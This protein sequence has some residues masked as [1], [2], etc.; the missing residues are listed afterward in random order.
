VTRRLGAIN[1]TTVTASLGLPTGTHDARIDNVNYLPQDRQLGLGKFSGALL[2]DHVI[3]NIW[4]P[5]VIGGAVNYPGS[6]ND[7]ENYRAPNA[8]LY[9]YAGYL[10]G[11]LVPAAGLAVT[12]FK[13]HD[14]DRGQDSERPLLLG[15]INGSLEW[16]NP[17]VAVL[18]G[19]SLP[20]SREGREPWTVGLGL[21][22][23]PF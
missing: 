10:L 23:A 15:A 5:I 9:A 6:E 3:D 19:F 18:A 12:G 8:S 20:F 2:V 14:R 4:G 13:D 21:A 22:V 11:P 7:L 17:W 16:S 1:D